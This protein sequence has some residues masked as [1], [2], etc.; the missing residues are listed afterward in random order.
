VDMNCRIFNVGNWKLSI[1][2]IVAIDQTMSE[3]F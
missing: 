1:V 2:K 3:Q